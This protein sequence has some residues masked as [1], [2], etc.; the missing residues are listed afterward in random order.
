[1]R[2]LS[3]CL[4][5]QFAALKT[6]HAGNN[7]TQEKEKNADSVNLKVRLFCS[8]SSRMIFGVEQPCLQQQCLPLATQQPFS[9][10]F[11]DYF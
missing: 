10:S 11:A 2:L 9:L 3:F 4:H 6:I 7:C 5:I 8:D 1:M